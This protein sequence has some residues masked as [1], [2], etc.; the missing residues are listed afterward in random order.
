MPYTAQWIDTREREEFEIVFLVEPSAF[1]H[2]ERQVCPAGER[3]RVDRQLHVRVLFFSRLRLVVQDMYV[4][5]ANLEEVD[6]P[7]YYLGVDAQVK[8][9]RAVVRDILTGQVHRNF[10]GDRHGVVEEHEALQCLMPFLVV[11]RRGQRQRRQARRVIFFSRDARCEV[12]GK[13]RR[14][15]YRTGEEMVRICGTDRIEVS[16]EILETANV[17][18]VHQHVE[19]R[20]VYLKTIHLAVLERVAPHDLTRREERLSVPPQ[21]RVGCE[22]PVFCDPRADRAF[23]Y[24]NMKALPNECLSIRNGMAAVESGYRFEDCLERVHLVLAGISCGETV[25]AFIALVYLQHTHPVAT[26]AFSYG[27][28]TVALRTGQ[29]LFGVI[30]VPCRHRCGGH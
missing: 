23:G 7:G 24:V 29:S 6:V 14:A 3:E 15:L 18:R 30:Q 9:S 26:F 10:N 2:L 5:V 13:F 20:L 16:L 27:V 19:L 22:L 25:Q 21:A 17:C 12:C 11:R 1:K 8:G 28:W 4:A